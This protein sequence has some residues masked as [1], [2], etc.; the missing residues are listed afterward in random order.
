MMSLSALMNGL[1]YRTPIGWKQLKHSP[2]RLFVAC[3][4]VAFA[5][6]LIL[7]M[8]GMH[9]SQA[10]T[11]KRPIESFKADIFL[12][13][14]TANDLNDSGTLP[15]RRLDQALSLAAVKD[16]SAINIGAVSFRNPTTQEVQ[17]L[18]IYGIDP[19]KD[20]M[21]DPD[22]TTQRDKLKIA[23]SVLLDREAR[24]DFASLVRRAEN[25]EMPRV[26]LLGRTVAIEGLFS[27][28]GSFSADGVIFA[29]DQTFMRLVPRRSQGAVSAIVL[30]LAPGQDAEA[31]AADLR[32]LLPASD[33]KVLTKAAF[34]AHAVS[35]NERKRP[36][37]ILLYSA[38][39]IAFV[40]GTVI[41][42]QILSADVADHLGEYA[43]FKAMGFT[44]TYLLGIVF[45]EAVILACIGFVPGL[46]ASLGVYKL[47]AAMSGMPIFMPPSRAA[48]AFCF[49][50]AM[51][52]ISG[53]I[54]T[55]KLASADP[56][57]VFG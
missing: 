41:V 55:R 5:N 57:D 42:Y 13:S 25:G 3:T 2:S 51:C 43:T 32:R 10:V 18:S 28:G 31:V 29:S 24:G 9:G 27:Q 36:I 48:M 39:L 34:Q 19:D 6:L 54:A 49:T 8:W 46:I 33:T 53:A 35:Y 15:R 22:I 37:G 1:R 38:M 17:T 21:T 44:D 11:T 26:E 20:L 40:V 14:P 56:A 47:L 12:I 45:E 16:G 30:Q 52:F 4:G 50:L 7:M 23:D